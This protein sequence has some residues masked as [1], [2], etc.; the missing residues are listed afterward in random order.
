MSF[1]TWYFWLFF[2]VV[3]LGFRCLPFRV[4]KLF[5]LVASYWFYMSW[6]WR[7]GGLLLFVT[8]VNFVA[9]RRIP[10]ASNRSRKIWLWGSVGGSLAVLG[11]FKYYD[12]FAGSLAGF[13]GLPVEAWQL[14][15]ILP[16]GISFYTFQGLSYTIDVA[17]GTMPPARSFTDFALYVAFFPQL[18]AGPIVRAS[19]FLP[20][21]DNWRR[22]TQEELSEGI[23][24]VLLGLVKKMVFAD[25]FAVVANAYFGNLPL[26]AGVA[27]AWTGVVAFSMQIYFDFAGY[28]D[29]ARGCGLL[30][31][32]RFNLNFARP[33]LAVDMRE[34]WHRWHISLSTWLRDYLYIPLGGS[35]IG[36]VRT[37]VNLMLTMLLGGLWHGASWT[38]VA[39]GGYHGALLAI[40]RLVRP[41]GGEG[42]PFW[43]KSVAGR[44]CGRGLTFLLACVG[45]VF[46]RA[47]TFG[48]ASRI[49]REMVR[50]STLGDFG[51]ARGHWVLLGCAFG[52]MWVQERWRWFDRMLAAPDWVR[53]LL[54]TASLY[55]LIL[56]SFTEKAIPFVYFQF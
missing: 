15:V 30:L 52:G 23:G 1:A 55:V 25:Q 29:I 41:S 44:W 2:L 18:V 20:Q 36:R 8:A 5:L 17:R 27:S 6:D 49:L 46:F 56:F 51:F 3:V 50:F 12:F 31:G 4:G 14:K 47:Q 35:R 45:W 48:D 22:P 33:Y 37:Y 9:S 40:D 34:F 16:V 53:G 7:F 24:L 19:D 13:A 42:V 21:L 39:W 28:T 38:F 43:A 10:N 26:H 32:F 54:L 11:F